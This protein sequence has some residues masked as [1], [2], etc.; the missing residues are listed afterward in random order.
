MIVVKKMLPVMQEAEETFWMLQTAKTRPVNS[1]YSRT[2]SS[3][4]SWK[5]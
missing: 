5:S 2:L 1:S 3:R 4:R